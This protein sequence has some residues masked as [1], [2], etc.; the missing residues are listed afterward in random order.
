MLIAAISL[1]ITFLV[2][3]F[4]RRGRENIQATD[5]RQGSGGSGI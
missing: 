4:V 5:G 3:R 1:L 2:R